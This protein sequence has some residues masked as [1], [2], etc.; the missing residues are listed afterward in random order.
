MSSG[1]VFGRKSLSELDGVHPDLV[2][3][4][5]RALELTEVD[6]TVHD[7]LRS[8]E[9]QRRYVDSGRSKTMNSKHLKQR[10]GWGHA[11]DLVP[12]DGGRL[13]WEW[14]LVYP[15]AE[16]VRQAA[17]E[18]G[19]GVRWGGCWG[20]LDKAGSTLSTEDLV[21]AYIAE[22]RS[23]GRIPFADG[24]HYEIAWG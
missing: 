10:D 5:H 8:I 11:V 19:V 20:R 3:V 15:I 2:K 22:R 4:A 9:T 16:A 23:Q 21:S 17:I 7:G 14:R 1:F 12:Y 24:P 13:K 18:L 6:F